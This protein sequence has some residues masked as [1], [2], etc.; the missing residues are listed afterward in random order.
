MLRSAAPVT[1][2]F[3]SL[4]YSAPPSDHPRDHVTTPSGQP[5]RTQTHKTDVVQM[6]PTG[7]TQMVKLLIAVT[8]LIVSAKSLRLDD[9]VSKV[10]Q[11]GVLAMSRYWKSTRRNR[12]ERLEALRDVIPGLLDRKNRQPRST[13]TSSVTLGYGASDLDSRSPR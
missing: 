4:A 8:K 10:L 11:L 12:H 5:R 6:P 9:S 13:G 3:V 7:V 2:S 1:E